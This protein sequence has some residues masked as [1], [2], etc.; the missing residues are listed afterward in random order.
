MFLKWLKKYAYL[1]TVLG[2]A[3]CFSQPEPTCRIRGYVVAYV[4]YKYV[5]KKQ[6]LNFL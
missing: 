2:F 4:M 5:A 1:E 6:K 3:Y